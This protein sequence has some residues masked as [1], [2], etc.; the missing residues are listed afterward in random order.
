M[1]FA[2]FVPALHFAARFVAEAMVNPNPVPLHI[3]GA[4]I[5]PLVVSGIVFAPLVG[6]AL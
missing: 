5:V 2:Y 1:S 4:A 6:G 3:P